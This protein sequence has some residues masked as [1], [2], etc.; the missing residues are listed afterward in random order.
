MWHKGE[1]YLIIECHNCVEDSIDKYSTRNLIE[2]LC[3]NII[4]LK[5]YF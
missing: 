2:Y 1:L 3:I 5:K 4:I